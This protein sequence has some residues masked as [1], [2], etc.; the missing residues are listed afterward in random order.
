MKITYLGHSSF[1]IE[2]DKGRIVTDPFRDIG[3]DVE[4]VDCDYCLVSHEHFDHNNTSGVNAKKVV[5]ASGE[6]FVVT[7]SFHDPC[8]G[9]AR[10]KNRIFSFTVDGIRCCHLGDIGEYFSSDLAEELGE[11][12]VL[13]IPVGGNYTIDA[14]EAVRYTEGIRPKV[15]IP[16]HYKTARSS[17]D[18]ASVDAFAKK[19][20]GVERT[21]RTIV[22]TKETLPEDRMVYIMNADEGG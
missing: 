18:I 15:V 22:L 14:T 7:D 8:L 10:G 19:S 6:G 4:R 11:V 9:G 21:G 2:G 16:M 1:L 12:D 13:M 3:Y 17:I 20:C 5:T